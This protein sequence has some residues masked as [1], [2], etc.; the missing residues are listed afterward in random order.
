MRSP[1]DSAAI[2]FAHLDQYT[3]GDTALESEILDLFLSTGRETLDAMEAGIRGEA[4]SRSAHKLKGSALAIGA[5]S[6][7]DR[8]AIAERMED[9]EASRLAMLADLRRQLND[10]GHVIRNRIGQSVA[11]KR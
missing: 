6:L 8:A 11:N 7:A 10:L 3:A 9:D 5:W 4:W 2:D 1:E